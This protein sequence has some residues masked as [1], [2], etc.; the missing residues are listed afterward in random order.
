[1]SVTHC[2]ISGQPLLNPVVCVR[3]G[4]VFEKKVVLKHVEATG[5]CPITGA[6]VTPA[7]FIDL[8]VNPSVKPRPMSATSIPSLIETFQTEWDALIL[9]QQGLKKHMDQLRQELSHALYQND[10]ATRVIARLLKEREE[11]RAELEQYKDSPE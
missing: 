1:M 6:E 9:E 4:L 11:L 10:A 2:A 5:R 8:Q 3:T 7:D